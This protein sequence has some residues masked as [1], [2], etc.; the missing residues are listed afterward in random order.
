MT[1]KKRRERA[2]ALVRRHYATQ[3]VRYPMGR[4]QVDLCQVADPVALAEKLCSKKL[5]GNDNVPYW[6]QIWPASF[7]LARYIST[8]KLIPGIPAIELGCG[9]GLSGVA[10][11]LA[12]ADVTFTDYKADTLLMARANHMLNLGHPGRAR[13]LD[14]REPARIDPAPL[15]IAADVLYDPDLAEPLVETID[16]V[17]TVGGTLWLAHPGREAAEKAV[18]LL[19]E[20]GYLHKI[21]LEQMEHEGRPLDVWVHLFRRSR[22][23]RRKKRLTASIGDIK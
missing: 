11:A 21:H 14:W 7:G 4:M 13:V 17:L 16:S 10:A 1:S 8:L 18:G 6:A 19:E 2:L 22:S 20:R 3:V 12:G 9:T 5:G 15:V 23:Q